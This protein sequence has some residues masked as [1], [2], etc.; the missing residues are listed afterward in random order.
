MA[1]LPTVRVVSEDPE[2]DGF[3]V[4]NE[5]DFNP[6]VHKKWAKPKTPRVSKKETEV[7]DAAD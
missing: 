2:H 3:I 1:E 4:I 6:E 7:E 5:D